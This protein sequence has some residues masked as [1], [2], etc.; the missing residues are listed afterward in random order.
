[1]SYDEQEYHRRRSEMELESAISAEE[2]ESAI[3]H[4]TLAR[5]HRE[6]RQLMAQARLQMRRRQYGAPILRADKEG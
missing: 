6:R 5:M 2:P 1:M 3:A 4:L